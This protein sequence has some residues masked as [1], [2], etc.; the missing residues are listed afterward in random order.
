MI[1]TTL[2]GVGQDL[3]GLVA[4]MEERGETVVIP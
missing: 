2:D 1:T 4:A 3:A